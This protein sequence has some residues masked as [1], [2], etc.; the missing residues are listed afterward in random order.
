M[1]MQ[2]TQ[3]NLIYNGEKKRT[4]SQPSFKLAKSQAHQKSFTK[5]SKLNCKVRAQHVC[6]ECL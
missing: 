4:N 5:Q 6:L 2:A 1:R 3:L